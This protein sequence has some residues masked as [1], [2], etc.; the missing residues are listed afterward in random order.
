MVNLPWK[1][2]CKGDYHR[3]SDEQKQ[4]QGLQSEYN[5]DLPEKRLKKTEEK[6]ETAQSSKEEKGMHTWEKGDEDHADGTTLEKTLFVGGAT[7]STTRLE[8][9][10]P[11]K[12]WNAFQKENAGK[13]WGRA[14]TRRRMRMR[15]S[16]VARSLESTEQQVR[17]CVDFAALYSG[18]GSVTS[19]A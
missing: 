5:R 18:L 17:W 7:S 3:G 4:G 10:K 14:T 8:D 16:T 9:E 13:A 2:G 1:S 6:E 12:P 15:R 11:K 19:T